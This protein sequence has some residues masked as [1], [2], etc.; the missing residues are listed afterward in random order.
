[1]DQSA[2]RKST[3]ALVC[4]SQFDEGGSGDAGAAVG[5][6]VD[7]RAV[8]PLGG[9][10]VVDFAAQLGDVE[11]M[12]RVGFIQP[13]QVRHDVGIFAGALRDEH[14]HAGRRGSR[15]GPGSLNYNGVHRLVRHGDGSDFADLQTGAQEFDAR[16]A[17]GIAFE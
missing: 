17:Q 13:D 5:R 12:L 11:A 1:M 9:G 10:D 15:A 4:D 8:G 6:L 2:L 16:H 3:E 14:V 7:H